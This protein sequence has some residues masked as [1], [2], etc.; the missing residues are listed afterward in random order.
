MRDQYGLFILQKIPIK[1][2]GDNMG[3]KGKEKAVKKG[4]VNKDTKGGQ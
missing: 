2:E 4:K 1:K 3:C